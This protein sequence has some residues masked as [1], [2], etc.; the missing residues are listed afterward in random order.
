[1]EVVAFVVIVGLVVLGFWLGGFGFLVGLSVGAGLVDVVGF[2]L[3]S[4][5][6]LCLVVLCTGGIGSAD[7]YGW[8]LYGFRGWI[9]ALELVVLRLLSVYCCFGLL[10]CVEICPCGGQWWDFVSVI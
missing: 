4:C 9:S 10:I 8:R 7:L 2:D 5:G 1:M 3:L 6:F